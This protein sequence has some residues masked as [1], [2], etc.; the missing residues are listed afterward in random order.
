MYD[1][2]PA[3]RLLRI[4][5]WKDTVNH[6]KHKKVDLSIKTDY[7]PHPAEFDKYRIYPTTNVTIINKDCI[8][9]AQ[10]YAEK[11]NGV[12]L[13]NMADWGKAGGLVEGGVATQEEECFRRSDYHLHLLQKYYPLD[14]YDLIVSKKVQYYKAGDAQKF[15]L[16]DK[17]FVVDMIASPALAG[18]MTDRMHERFTDPNDIDIM[19][20]KI[21]QLIWQA[22]I[23]KNDVLVL[24]AWG[25]GAFACPI[26]HMA[27]L[28]KEVIYE[29]KGCIPIIVFAIFGDSYKTFYNTF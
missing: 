7:V 21:R 18:P 9:V 13:L 29:Q 10:E 15:A 4:T 27:E 25:C 3:G 20:N 5:T 2:T 28:F 11:G 8:D 12:M 22:C 26:K 14:T 16:L 1:F 17:P 19:R 23:N 24:S 6:Y